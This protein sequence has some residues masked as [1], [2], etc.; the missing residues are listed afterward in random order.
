MGCECG[1]QGR[2]VAKG[3]S[4]ELIDIVGVLGLAR[5]DEAGDVPAFEDDEGAVTEARRGHDDDE[6]VCER[7]RRERG[8]K[9][10]RDRQAGC[11][12]EGMLMAYKDRCTRRPV[13]G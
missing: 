7:E 9:R 6:G 8:A 2:A 5:D 13:F 1:N 12:S 11:Y 10:C 3:D 4:L